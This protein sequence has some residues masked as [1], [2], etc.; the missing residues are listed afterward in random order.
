MPLYDVTFEDVGFA[1]DKDIS[2]SELGTI[3]AE[4]FSETAR[5]EGLFPAGVLAIVRGGISLDVEDDDPEDDE[6]G[7]HKRFVSVTLRVEAEDE[8]AASMID[9]PRQ[10]LNTIAEMIAGEFSFD[11]EGNW[12]LMDS[13]P[14]DLHAPEA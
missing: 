14:A 6:E 8:D 7:G 2:G 5:S 13:V 10:I 4:A 1:K 12:E 3:E 9:P 11:M